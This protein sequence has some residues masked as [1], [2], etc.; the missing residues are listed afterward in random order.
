MTLEV[1]SR[2]NLEIAEYCLD[3]KVAISSG[4]SRAYY[5]AY[6]MAKGYLIRNGVSDS[7]YAAKANDWKVEIGYPVRKFAHESIWKLVKAHMRVTRK[8]GDGL[9][10]AGLGESLHR[11]RTAADYTE[12][13][14][15]ADR[16]ASCIK[17]AKGL[18]IALSEE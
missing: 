4:V 3:G 15:S 14:F 10:I 7:N 17:Q 6:Q 2:E 5:A 12:R 8:S 16:L 1:K 9:K 18:I 13:D 11:E